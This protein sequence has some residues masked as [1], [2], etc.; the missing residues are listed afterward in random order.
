M[1]LGM[2]IVGLLFGIW[3]L[4]DAI[5]GWGGVRQ[6]WINFVEGNPPAG[7][8]ERIGQGAVGGIFVVL[9]VLLFAGVPMP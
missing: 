9:A 5:F 4:L 3:V 1:K 7:T 6:V 8:A 2:T